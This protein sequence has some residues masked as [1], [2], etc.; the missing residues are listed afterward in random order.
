MYLYN[1]V[2]PITQPKVK[3]HAIVK[4]IAGVNAS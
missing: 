3:V 2:S 1:T 4:K